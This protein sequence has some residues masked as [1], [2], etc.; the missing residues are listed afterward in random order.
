MIF[1]NLRDW[2]S[3]CALYVYF[4][5]TAWYNVR[6]LDTWKYFFAINFGLIFDWLKSYF[7]IVEKWSSKGSY[8]KN[9]FSNVMKVHRVPGQKS[10]M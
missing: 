1:T 6:H 4:F 5:D 2:N 9:D 7:L 8:A 10:K 3:F